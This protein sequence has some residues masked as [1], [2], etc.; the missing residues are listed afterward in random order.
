MLALPGTLVSALEQGM[1]ADLG[2]VGTDNHRTAPDNDVDVP[3]GI[4]PGDGIE[5]PVE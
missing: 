1:G 5:T 4:P 3:S 2:A